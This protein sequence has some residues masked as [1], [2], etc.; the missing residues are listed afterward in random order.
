MMNVSENKE[1]PIYFKLSNSPDTVKIAVCIRR[2]VVIHNNVNTLYI[3]STTEDVCRYKYTF[4]E[5]FESSV[6][7]DTTRTQCHDGH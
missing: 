1:L 5:C 3:D 6:P 2:A 7:V 4:F